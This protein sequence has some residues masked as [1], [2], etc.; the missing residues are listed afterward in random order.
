MNWRPYAKRLADAVS[1]EQSG[2]YGP[3][4]DTPRH[5]FV[6]CWW[7]NGVRK[8][9]HADKTA[10]LE[11]AYSDRSLVT[12]I[13]PLHAEQA[14]PWDRPQGAPTS[15]STM[16]SLLLTMYRHGRLYHGARILDVGTGSGY[17]TALL[18]KRYGDVTVSSIDVDQYLVDTAR[19]RLRQLGLKPI[20]ARL[21]ATGPIPGTYDRII[22][23]TAVRPI[24][25]SWLAA[26]APGGR[27]VT[28]ITGLT[29]VLTAD[30]QP[31]GS[32]V[33]RIEF[34]RA[35][36]MPARHLSDYP[37]K[38]TRRL[39][40]AIKDADGEE[41]STGRYPVVDVAQAWELCSVL[42]ITAPGIE[43]FY[44]EDADGLRT[45]WMVHGDGS[46]ARAT[47]YPMDRAQVHQGGP[48][49]LWEIFDQVRDFWASHGYLQ[50]YGAEV[51]IPPDASEIQL[52]RGSWTATIT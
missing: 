30:R 28:S 37:E 7:E 17:G 19:D 48:R 6:P 32:A 34:D 21:D 45:A 24:P 4:C 46:W 13:G 18:C 3:I 31:D 40:L 26:L 22:A 52:R 51:Y 42:D 20:I 9:G 43:H 12:R 50:L 11:A 39:F 8:N 10:W 44:E 29:V 16:A 35:G 23:T 1:W 14:K 38:P 33:G 36:F 41:I 25:R 27:I 49:R 2:W 5:L 15:S 47:G